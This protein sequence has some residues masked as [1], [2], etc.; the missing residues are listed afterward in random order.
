MNP[1]DPKTDDADRTPPEADPETGAE[2]GDHDDAAPLPFAPHKDDKS[3]F[4]DT[5]QHSDA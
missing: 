1:P 2:G 5:D 3:A 4:G